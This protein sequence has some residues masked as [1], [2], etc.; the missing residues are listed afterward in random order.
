MVQFGNDEADSAPIPSDEQVK[1]EFA[2]VGVAEESL[3]SGTQFSTNKSRSRGRRAAPKRLLR[4]SWKTRVVLACAAAAIALLGWAML[5]RALAPTENT[6]QDHFDTLIVLGSPVDEDG[7]PTPI[8]LAR[9]TEAVKEYERGIAPRII[10]TG[11]AV[12]N[13]FVE[14]HVMAQT[15]EAQGIPASAVFVDGLSRNT[16]ENTCNALAIMRKHGW[17][18]AEVISSP[19]HLPRA[20]LILNQLPMKWRVQ[21]APAL[22]PGGEDSSAYQAGREIL[23]T[24]YYLA[25]SRHTEPCAMGK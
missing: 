6:P 4:L 17:E 8:E 11:G 7:N 22:E 21:A 3:L 5:E 13:R 23:K 12:N 18:S 16:I 19:S 10:F 15:A 24:L 20:G 14:A 1:V 2:A 9:V 25:W